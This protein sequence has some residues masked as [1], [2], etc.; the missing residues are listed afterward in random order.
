MRQDRA[1]R[2]TTAIIAILTDA[3]RNWFHG[4][5]VSFTAVRDEIEGYLRDEF[6]DCA[7]QARSEYELIDD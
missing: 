2:A 3:W 4:D 5:G 1:A 6:S 7:H